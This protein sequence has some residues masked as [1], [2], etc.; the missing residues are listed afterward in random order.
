MAATADEF[1]GAWRVS[2]EYATAISRTRFD[3]NG[4]KCS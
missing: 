4:S 2:M 1:G 3:E